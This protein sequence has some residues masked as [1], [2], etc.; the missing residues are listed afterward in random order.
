MR[1][2][3]DDGMTAEAKRVLHAALQLPIEDREEIIGMLEESLDDATSED[4]ETAWIEEVRR[5]VADVE[6]GK[7]TL[8]SSEST[9]QMRTE[10]LERA[11]A[12]RAG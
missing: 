12:R 1:L 7:A 11:R 6:S 2:G 5:R 9:R 8:V 4:I 10:I 3:Y